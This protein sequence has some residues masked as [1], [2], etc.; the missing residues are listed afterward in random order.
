MSGGPL[1]GKRRCAAE[2]WRGSHGDCSGRPMSGA[3]LAAGVVAAVLV[4][5]CL[6]AYNRLVRLRQAIGEAFREVAAVLAQRHELID[7]WLRVPQGD[8]DTADEG[9][10]RDAVAAACRQARA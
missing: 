8:A 2:R 3:P 4:C 6:G 7:E 1:A 9:T 5:W 10:N